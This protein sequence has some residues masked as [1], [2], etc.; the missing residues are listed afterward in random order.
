MKTKS[1][2]AVEKFLSGYNCAQSVLYAY[3]PDLGLGAETALK[4]ATGLGGG[5][6]G[7]GEVCG[8]VTG[9]IL[10]LGLKYGR[11]EQAEKS[12]A[13]Q[14]YQKTGE[15]MAAFER[16]HGSYMCR[17]LLCGCDLRTPE[18]MQRFK[19][20]DLHHK[21]CVGCVRTVGEILAGMLDEPAPQASTERK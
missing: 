8:A 19:E 14:A 16:V 7:R 21:V 4:V 6:G 3:G 17:T 5:M 20:Q 2:M 9:G 1:E 10:A 15:L 12:V 11:G 13:Q 18:G